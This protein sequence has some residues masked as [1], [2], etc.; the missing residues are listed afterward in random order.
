MQSVALFKLGHGDAAYAAAPPRAVPAAERRGLDRAKNVTRPK[1]GSHKAQAQIKAQ[2][3]TL[4]AE[5][6]PPRKTGTDDEWT[7]F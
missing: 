3:S 5:A 6:A 4:T 1:F 2:A 7:S